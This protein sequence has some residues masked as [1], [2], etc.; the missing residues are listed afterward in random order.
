MIVNHE[1]GHWF[2]LDHAECPASGVPAPIMMQQSKGVGVCLPNAW[3][4]Q[5]ER[6]AVRRRLG[7]PR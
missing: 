3:P 4:T 2:G 6:E 7:V 5:A 1:T